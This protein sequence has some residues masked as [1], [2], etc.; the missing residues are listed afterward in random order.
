MKRTRRNEIV[1]LDGMLALA[2][3][4]GVAGFLR[5]QQAPQEEPAKTETIRSGSAQEAGQAAKPDS[6][7]ATEESGKVIRVPSNLVETPV[8]VTDSNGDFVFGLS[9]KDFHIFD[10]G[11]P[12]HI[13]NFIPETRPLAVVISFMAVSPDRAFCRC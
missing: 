8:T 5:A 10:N 13:Q 11:I 12:Q 7:D 6:R 1:V 2:L 3:A 4:A 9:E